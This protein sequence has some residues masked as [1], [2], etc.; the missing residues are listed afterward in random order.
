MP[1]LNIFFFYIKND[2]SAHRR[3]YFINATE[4]VLNQDALSDLPYLLQ[5]QFKLTPTVAF[6]YFLKYFNF[7]TYF[8][9]FLKKLTKF[10]LNFL[11][12]IY[13]KNAF[14]Y[15]FFFFFKIQKTN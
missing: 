14:Y 5:K 2:N 10:K 12:H 15:N 11:F 6:C 7:L 1:V 8:N 13:K 3:S 9:F 4:N